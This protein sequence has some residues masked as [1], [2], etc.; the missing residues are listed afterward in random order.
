MTGA[1]PAEDGG[2]VGETTVV[3]LGEGSASDIPS[4]AHNLGDGNYIWFSDEQFRALLH[5]DAVVKAITARADGVCN[6]CNNT[7]KK[8]RAEYEVIV[9]NLPPSESTR[10]RAFVRP[11]NVAARYDDAVNSTMLKAAANAPNDPKP[12]G[13]DFSAPQGTSGEEGGSVAADIAEVAVV[14]L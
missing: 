3:D 14:A 6:E 11:A 7:K 8:K 13:G 5:S 4:G 12:G 10:A 9:Q 2:E 1:L